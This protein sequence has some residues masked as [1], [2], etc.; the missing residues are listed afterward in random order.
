[1]APAAV[2]R[3]LA[4]FLASI[5]KFMKKS[6]FSVETKIDSSIL[7]SGASL[8]QRQARF[9]RQFTPLNSSELPLEEGNFVGIDAEFVTLNQVGL[10]R[11]FRITI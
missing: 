3:K 11:V 4:P 8:A 1:M 7:V 9:S 2:A 6:F 5:L 10:D